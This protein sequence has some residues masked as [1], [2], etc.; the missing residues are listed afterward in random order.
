LET[1]LPTYGACE[2]REA[3]PRRWCDF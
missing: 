2:R 1:T 3:R